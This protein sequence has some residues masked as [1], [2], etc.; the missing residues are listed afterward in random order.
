ME[1]HKYLP[2]KFSQACDDLARATGTTQWI[3]EQLQAKQFDEEMRKSRSR[4][5]H[6]N[7][8]ISPVSNKSHKSRQINLSQSTTPMGGMQPSIKSDGGDV[9][10]SRLIELLDSVRPEDLRQTNSEVKSPRNRSPR[11]GQKGP[12]EPI[13]TPIKELT[14]STLVHQKKPPLSQN[15]IPRQNQ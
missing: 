6:S 1:E 13:M 4:S 14:K 5:N 9:D 2:P 8:N 7:H 3:E 12:F 15:T 11:K 10:H